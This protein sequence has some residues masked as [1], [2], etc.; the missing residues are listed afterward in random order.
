MRWINKSAEPPSSLREYVAAQTP[1]GHGL[2]YGTFASTAAPGGGSRGGQLRREL[3]VEQC[4]L[5]AYTG[6]GIDSR[7]GR[8]EDAQ[9]AGF[10]NTSQYVPPSGGLLP[11]GSRTGPR[12][13]GCDPRDRLGFDEED[14]DS[15]CLHWTLAVNGLPVATIE[16]KNP[17]T[18]QNWRHAVRQYKED[19]AP[20]APLFQRKIPGKAN[21]F[22]L[23]FVSEEEDIYKAFK[24]YCD[25]TSLQ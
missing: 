21:R 12:S 14:Q 25:A 13:H 19:R 11:R 17:G 15:Q 8:L 24:P 10:P 16:L 7:V 20:R 6:A 4:G 2:D 9:P 18:S 22:L 23:D 1:V 5:C 3:T